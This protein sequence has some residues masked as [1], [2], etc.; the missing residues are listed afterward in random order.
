MLVLICLGGWESYWR[1]QGYSPSV[2]DNWELWATIRRQANQRQDKTVALIGSSRIQLG[3]HPDVFVRTSNIR[4]LMLA[5]DGNSPLPILQNLAEDPGFSGLVICG[6]TPQWL[7]EEKTTKRRVSKWIRKYQ[8]QKWSSRLEAR[9]ATGVQQLFVFRFPGLSPERIRRH[10]T[11]GERLKK[12][13]APMRPDRY[14]PADYTKTDLSRLKNTRE[15][16]TRQQAANTLSLSPDGFRERIEQISLW[17][18]KIQQRGGQ[19]I[20][21]RM[22]SA[23]TI[24]EI[25]ETTWPR[26]RYWN[27]FATQLNELTIHFED[28][29]ALSGFPSPD[30]SHLNED[31]ASSFTE[32]L[33]NIL[34]GKQWGS[35]A[36]SQ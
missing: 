14:R 27:V 28:Y 35:G 30:G 20:F 16:R 6:L 9:L 32:A 36:A 31:S 8:K 18:E 10:L 11:H 23:G 26:D 21:L 22:P 17:V 12:V 5:I 29:P 19:V 1:L 33:V 24:R 34:R 2:E 25:E 15:K 7:A 3:L 4:P 13:Y